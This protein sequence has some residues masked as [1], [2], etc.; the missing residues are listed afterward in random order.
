MKADPPQSSPSP[1]DQ[2]LKAV[3]PQIEALGIKHLW[4]FGSRSRGD[5]K[6]SSDCD[7]LVEFG[8]PP[9]FDAFMSLKLMLEDHLEMP[10]DLL[11]LHALPPRWL[12]AIQ[13]GL[14]RVA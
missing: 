1:I 10:V 2:R 14:L 12:R 9:G 6:R 8:D 4:I 7:I 3:W 5:H 11:S 13:P